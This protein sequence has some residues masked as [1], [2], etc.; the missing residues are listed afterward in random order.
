MSEENTLRDIFI[1]VN[2]WQSEVASESMYRKY[3]PIDFKAGEEAFG[4][5]KTVFIKMPGTGEKS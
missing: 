1:M 5:G 2:T 3:E 4:K